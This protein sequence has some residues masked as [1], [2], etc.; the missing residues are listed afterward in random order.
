L[1]SSVS[2]VRANLL[3]L[4]KAGLPSPLVNRVLRIAAFQNPEF[5]KAQAMRL[6]T[7]G[8]PRVISCG[9]KLDRY[10]ALPR[11]CLDELIG[12]L[13]ESSIDAQVRDVRIEGQPIEVRFSGRLRSTQK[14]AVQAILAHD[15]GV[16]SAP[17][18]SGKTAVAAYVIAARKINT[19][20][21][22]HRRQL[23]D[24]WRERLRIF[25]DLPP[26]SIGQVGGGK[27]APT[28]IVDV[29]VVQSLYV[30]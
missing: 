3:F 11:G 30:K 8:K 18:G 26:D 7:F 4:E 5:Y 13:Q 24:Q 21:L 9:E 16:L 25:L 22:V 17:T 12:L 28:G 6:S 20:I 2:V 14:D 29:A 19:L 23:L 10:I 27:S 1:P 15:D